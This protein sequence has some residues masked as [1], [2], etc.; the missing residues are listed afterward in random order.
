MAFDTVVGAAGEGPDLGPFPTSMRDGRAGWLRVGPD[1][2]TSH[3]KV[4]AAGDLKTGPATVVAAIAGGRRAAGAVN[5]SLGVEPATPARANGGAEG[6]VAREEVN[7]SYFP[8]SMPVRERP[9]DAEA[10]GSEERLTISGTE[11]LLE[12][13]RC[14]SCGHCN[15]CGTCFVFCPDSA[16]TWERGPVIDLDFCKG[17]GICAVECPGHVLDFVR[18][19][20]FG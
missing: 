16:I 19:S 10:D 9:A 15:A 12:I 1:G 20:S 17:C 5:A 4:F 3:R 6:V 7:L 2:S 11:V 14:L 13:G 18:E 8:R